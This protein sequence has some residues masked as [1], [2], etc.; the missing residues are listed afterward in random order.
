MKP[1]LPLLP[2]TVVG[3]HGTPSWLFWAQEGI[4]QGK[5]GPADIKETL[6]DAVRL[7]IMD[8]FRTLYMSQP[9]V[10]S[11]LSAPGAP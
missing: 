8:T 1:D 5:F 10:F 4:R 9:T 7:A 11:A 3:S 2:T 6:D